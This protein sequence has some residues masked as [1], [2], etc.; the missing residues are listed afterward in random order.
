VVSHSRTIDRGKPHCSLWQDG[1]KCKAMIS[2]RSKWSRQPAVWLIIAFCSS[3]QTQ[4]KR[5][6]HADWIWPHPDATYRIHQYEV[7]ESFCSVNEEKPLCDFLKRDSDKEPIGFY[8][9]HRVVEVTLGHREQLVLINDFEATKSAKVVV[10]NLASG[11]Q[12]QIDKRALAMYRRHV[13]PDHRLWISA[14][15]Y[16][17]SAN[18]RQVLIKM[19]LEDVG[20]ATVE[21]SIAAS[22]TY[23]EWWY[24]VDSQSGRVICEFRAKQFPA[25]WWHCRTR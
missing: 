4:V 13:R 23:R 24:A 3:V 18:D 19:V 17:F 16:E 12:K 7:T 8:A 25:R 11:I 6:G 22:R 15:A 5:R 20:A 2:A 9:H 14:E 10:A 1:V 21:E